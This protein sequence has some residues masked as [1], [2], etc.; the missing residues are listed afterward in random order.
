MSIKLT[1]ALKSAGFQPGTH[2]ASTIVEAIDPVIIAALP[3]RILAKLMRD[4][5]EHWH[6]AQGR[7]EAEIVSEGCVWSE[8]G[9]RLLEIEQD[10]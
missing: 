3:S 10:E 8:R 5:H 1:R 2:Q 9:K 4:M 6:Q 7:K